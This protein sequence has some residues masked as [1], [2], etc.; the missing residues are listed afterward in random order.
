MKRVVLMGVTVLT[1]VSGLALG[2]DTYTET[3]DVGELPGTAV[4]LTG[5]AIDRIFGL[6][7]PHEADMF[8]IYIADPVAFSA[9]TFNPG[10]NFDTML[11]LFDESGN[12]VYANDDGPSGWGLRSLLPAG[13]DLSPKLAGTYYLAVTNYSNDPLSSGGARL[14]AGSFIDVKAPTG[15]GPITSWDGQGSVT[16]D[17]EITLTGVGCAPTVIPAPG[18]GLLVWIGL[19]LSRHVLRRAGRKA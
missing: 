19:G 14:F 2:A 13:D 7:E 8:R 16:G 18:A 3:G 15:V 4:D 1:L 17:Y 11:L 10:S 5:L 9:S 12:G 6:V